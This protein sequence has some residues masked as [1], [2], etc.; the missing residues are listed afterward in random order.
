MILRMALAGLASTS[1]CVLLAL[2]VLDMLSLEPELPALCL[3]SGVA[4]LLALPVGEMEAGVVRPLTGSA[5]LTGVI[6][7]ALLRLVRRCNAAPEAG[8]LSDGVLAWPAWLSPCR[9]GVTTV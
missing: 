1:K 3:L 5:M 8:V 4:L 2:P 6:R 7:P 9:C